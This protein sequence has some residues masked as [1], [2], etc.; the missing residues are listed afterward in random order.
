MKTYAVVGYP[1][2]HSLSPAIQ[3]AAFQ[4]LEIPAKFEIFETKNLAE[5]VEKIRSKEIAGGSVTMP[6]KNEIIQYLDTV[7]EDVRETGACNCINGL[8][9]FNTDWQGALRALG[10]VCKLKNQRV[11]LI[12]VGGAGGAI[13]HGLYRKGIDPVI[14]NRT[15]RPGVRPLD[16]LDENFDI[17]INASS[18]GFKSDETCV[19][20]KILK[21]GKVVMDVVYEPLETRLIQNAKKAGCKI[22]TGEKMLLYQGAL[23]FEIWTGRKAPLD[24][25]KR[26]LYSSLKK[27]LPD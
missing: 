1:C 27:S 2:R 11:Y 13:F 6:Y 12:G 22:I 26:A 20:E 9:G 14:F 16:S 23:A 17:L 18:C 19:P 4:A 21:P 15:P 3:N 10:D 25:M 24:V 7:S 5:F 8:A